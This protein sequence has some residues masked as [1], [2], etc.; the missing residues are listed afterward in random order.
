MTEV[1]NVD[2]EDD[3]GMIVGAICGSIFGGLLF[4]FLAY[5]ACASPSEL[6]RK[7]TIDENAKATPMK[8]EGT[9][10]YDNQPTLP[11]Q[12]L[13]LPVNPGAVSNNPQYGVSSPGMGPYP[14]QFPAQPMPQ[15]WAPH[16]PAGY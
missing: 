14:G 12:N 2:D 7:F 10:L 5:S 15:G 16:A 11:V 4:A 9:V 3:T 13:G 8:T 6:A 1:T